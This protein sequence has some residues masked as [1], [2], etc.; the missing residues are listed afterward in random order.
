MSVKITDKPTATSMSTADK[1]FANIGGALK[2]I[3]KEMFLKDTHDKID[4][5][6]SNLS[7]LASGEHGGK[8]LFKSYKSLGNYKWR[9]DVT[10]NGHP[11]IYYNNSWMGAQANNVLKNGKTYTIS[12][13]AKGGGSIALYGSGSLG[14]NKEITSDWTR[15]SWV[16]T[17]WKDEDSVRIENI[18]DNKE[19]YIS[20]FQIEEGTQATEYE[21]Y[22]PSVAMLAEENEQQND[23]LSV[24]GKC[25]NL[26]KPTL[27]TTT[28]NIVTCTNNGDGTYTLNGTADIDRYFFI[29]AITDIAKRT[30]NKDYKLVGCP[31]GGVDCYDLRYEINGSV[32]NGGNKDFGNGCIVKN[33]KIKS[34]DITSAYI[35]ISI[36]PGYTA[37]NLV[38]KPM[39]TTNLNATYD[40]FVPY[41]GDGD[42]LTADVAKINSDLSDLIARVTALEGK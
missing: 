26:L 33:D 23:S 6:N 11:S 1:I 29:Q 27:Q 14:V 16:L 2:Q 8:N 42:T 18:S 3:T 15:I 17:A 22:I 21:P 39:L 28:Q 34:A 13:Y 32:N 24:L 7:N 35:I 37:N 20:C 38:F 25:K 36:M 41:T 5:V 10:Y 31:V 40:D 9:N 19:T 4:Q 30:T 12:C